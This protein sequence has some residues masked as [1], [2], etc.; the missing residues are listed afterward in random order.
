MIANGF[1]ESPRSATRQRHL[2]GDGSLCPRP[3]ARLGLG[4]YLADC[5][6]GKSVALPT[7]HLLILWPGTSWRTVRE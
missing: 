7:C 5:Q 3:G 6:L 4:Y 1:R 2:L